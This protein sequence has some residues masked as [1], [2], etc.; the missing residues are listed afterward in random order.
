MLRAGDRS[1][2]RGSPALGAG[3]ARIGLRG[4]CLSGA[5]L[6]KS[7]LRT[8]AP[9]AFDLQGY[10]AGW[11]VPDRSRRRRLR[12]R[13]AQNS[14]HLAAHPP[15][16]GDHVPE[17]VQA[18]GRPPRELQRPRP[19]TR[20]QASVATFLLLD[21]SSPCSLFPVRESRSLI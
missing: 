5:D 20:N 1:D 6:A 11:W 3:A 17:I 12:A 18:A 14:R 21:S 8:T 16:S 10:F 13:R 15:R 19:Q 9:D 7:E 4:M 2:D